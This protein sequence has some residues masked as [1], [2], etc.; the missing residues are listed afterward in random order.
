[1][2]VAFHGMIIAV[3]DLLTPI[4]LLFICVNAGNM[5]V[6]L[7]IRSTCVYRR[8][9]SQLSKIKCSCQSII[10]FRDNTTLPSFKIL[11]LPINFN[12]V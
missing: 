2:Q 6:Y 9:L 12:S 10:T 4:E 7:F 11:S 8:H 1:M 5:S 3:R